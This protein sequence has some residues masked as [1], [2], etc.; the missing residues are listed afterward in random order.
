M[1]LGAAPDTAVGVL[2]FAAILM[3]HLGLVL[4]ALAAVNRKP[5]EPLARLRPW[6]RARKLNKYPESLWIAV[7][8]V[9][10]ISGCG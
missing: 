3:L 7:L 4:E 8:V 6:K 1:D 2:F 9:A 5:A 10:G